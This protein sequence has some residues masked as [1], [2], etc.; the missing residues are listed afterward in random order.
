MNRDRIFALCF[1][2]YPNHG[3]MPTILDENG[4]EVYR[5]E[6]R[7]TFAEAVFHASK[8]IEGGL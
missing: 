6:Y 3:Y 8:Q 2:Y 7:A 5:G 4:D 1:L